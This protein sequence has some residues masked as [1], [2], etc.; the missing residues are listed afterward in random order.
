M[1][2]KT[3]RGRPRRN[4]R[5]PGRASAV[6]VFCLLAAVSSP[7]SAL[8]ITGSFRLGTL[9]FDAGRE[10]SET[11][12]A[13]DVLQW[14]AQIGVRQSLSDEL[15]FSSNFDRD[16]ILRNT[17]YN[18]LTFRQSFLRLGVGPFFGV[19]NST[20]AILKPGITT[21]VQVEFPGLAYLLF[22]SDSTIGGR[23]VEVLDYTQERSD[24]AAGLYIGNVIMSAN[25][26]SRR[27]SQKTAAEVETVDALTVYALETDI[28]RKNAPYKALISFGYHNLTRSFIHPDETIK[29]TLNSI[30]LGTSVDIFL[31]AF[32]TTSLSLESSIYTFGGGELL[33][34]SNPGPGG[35]LFRTYVGV[36]FDTDRLPARE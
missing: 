4:I 5:V 22:R 10:E 16:L 13:G 27:F 21:L 8:E 24:I 14:G 30:V 35:Y 18:T 6:A 32:L 28:F 11:T 36:T 34:V 23:L 12:F 15:S 7:L 26:R 17:I 31:T 19:L 25:L 1:S 20:T 29:H 9:G 33:G 3:I 2:T